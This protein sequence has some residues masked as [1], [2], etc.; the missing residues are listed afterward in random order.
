MTAIDAAAGRSEQSF[1]REAI[2]FDHSLRALGRRVH[3][4]VG[5]LGGGDIARGPSEFA[6]DGTASAKR[7]L[8]GLL[9]VPD[10]RRDVVS[11]PQGRFKNRRADVA[12]RASKK[13]AH[14]G[15]VYSSRSSPARSAGRRYCH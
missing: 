8:I 9:R 12:G 5:I 3:D 6:N 1:D 2:D 4:H 10:E 13:D 7:N 11:R 14:D 15:A